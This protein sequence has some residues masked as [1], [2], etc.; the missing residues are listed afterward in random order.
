MQKYRII[1]QYWN[2]SDK[3]DQLHAYFST[4]KKN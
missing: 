1:W 3:I 2:V 4:E